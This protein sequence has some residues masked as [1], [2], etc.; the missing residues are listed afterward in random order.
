MQTCQ[1]TKSSVIDIMDYA[2]ENGIIDDTA[3]SR[4]LFDTKCVAPS[5]HEVIRGFRHHYAQS[6][7]T[8]T[9]WYYET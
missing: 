6:P 7:Q 5:P 9:E 8:A 2:C 4:D 3:A 1:L